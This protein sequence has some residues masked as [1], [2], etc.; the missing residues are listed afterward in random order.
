MLLGKLFDE[1]DGTR[2]LSLVAILAQLRVQMDGVVT[3]DHLRTA[4]FSVFRLRYARKNE[5]ETR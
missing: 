5:E 3:G 2:G 4:G 1:L